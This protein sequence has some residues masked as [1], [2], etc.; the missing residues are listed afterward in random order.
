[1]NPPSLSSADV[2]PSD[3]RGNACRNWMR[4][5]RVAYVSILSLATITI[6]T[7]HT[8]LFPSR[9]AQS[10]I[11]ADRIVGMIGL[12]M[13]IPLTILKTVTAWASRWVTILIMILLLLRYGGARYSWTSVRYRMRAQFP[14]NVGLF[15]LILLVFAVFAFMF[16]RAY[17][18]SS[19]I[20]VYEP[21]TPIDCVS[22]LDAMPAELCGAR[23]GGSPSLCV[24]N[25]VDSP[26]ILLRD[27]YV[28]A[29][30]GR[31]ATVVEQAIEC[32]GV[33]TP[34]ARFSVVTVVNGTT[35][36]TLSDGVA[37][38]VQHWFDVISGVWVC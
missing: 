33:K 7:I 28:H 20:G 17:L 26:P 27:W 10:H 15:R 12:V 2:H 13:W 23:V 19:A 29:T 9:Y 21:P 37:F 14:K 18:R 36:V 3:V 8:I 16:V 38:C 31:A 1:M 22:I 35:P 30:S 6:S 4:H 24:R 5:M 11:V 32:P 25:G 34:R